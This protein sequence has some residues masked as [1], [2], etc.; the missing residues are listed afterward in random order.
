ML[1]LKEYSAT[2]NLYPGQVYRIRYR[3]SGVFEVFSVNTSDFIEAIAKSAQDLSDYGIEPVDSGVK[4]DPQRMIVSIYIRT[5]RTLP[6]DIWNDVFR[7][8]IR[9]VWGRWLTWVQRLDIDF[10]D[11]QQVSQAAVKKEIQESSLLVQVIKSG[12]IFGSLYLIYRL[13][14]LLKE[15]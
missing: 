2:I 13:I 11:C 15:K 8:N 7:R 4:Y 1:N 12:L 14:S 9:E 3:I 6:L 5:S 10:V